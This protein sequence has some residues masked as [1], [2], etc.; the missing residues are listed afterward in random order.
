MAVAAVR[1]DGEPLNDLESFTWGLTE[2]VS[3]MTAEILMPREQAI[4]LYNA[5]IARMGGGSNPFT[6]LSMVADV[7]G[8]VGESEVYNNIVVIGK[9]PSTFEPLNFMY[10]QIADNRWFWDK[11]QYAANFNVRTAVGDLASLRTV[12]ID[13]LG[14]IPDNII[15]EISYR[16]YSLYPPI[17]ERAGTTVLRP[18]TLR[19]MFEELILGDAPQSM[20]NTLDHDV[21]ALTGADVLTALDEILYEEV[22]LNGNYMSAL[23]SLLSFVPHVGI[24][25]DREG[26][27]KF[28]DKS[29]GE[30]QIASLLPAPIDGDGVIEFITNEIQIPRKIHCIFDIQS[31][32][33]FDYEEV[34]T[35]DSITATGEA[36]T[37]SMI[38]PVP[39]PT[40]DIIPVGVGPNAKPGFKALA[41]QPVEWDRV[42]ESLQSAY[43]DIPLTKALFRRYYC[44]HGLIEKFVFKGI[45]AY[46]TADWPEIVSTLKSTYRKNYRINGNWQSKMIGI[47]DKRCSVFD[48]VTGT[49]QDSP[50]FQDY[51]YWLNTKGVFALGEDF[52]NIIQNVTN[53]TDA[54]FLVNTA[55]PM[56]MATVSL[57]DSENG[58]FFVNTSGFD[59]IGH[60]KSIFPS[61]IVNPVTY[62]YA[63]GTKPHH[64]AEGANDSPE[65]VMALTTAHK[66][67]MIISA[68]PAPHP[69][70][71][72]YV[73]EVTPETVSDIV[74]SERLAGAVGP[75]LWVKIPSSV[76]LAR[77]RWKDG[78]DYEA[79]F[80]QLFGVGSAPEVFPE[81]LR[82]QV[83]N[84]FYLEDTAKATGAAIYSEL[85]HRLRGSQVNELE[86]GFEPKGSIT[87]ILNTISS[88]G[89]LSTR[90]ETNTVLDVPPFESFLKSSTRAFIFGHVKKDK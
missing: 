69:G 70:Q 81:I 83:V 80:E 15:D 73:L 26:V 61:T 67:S 17:R 86:P 14:S 32:L 40:L 11:G 34:N 31:E 13:T 55:I 45:L 58:V 51:S 5:G 16:S 88:S 20:K 36:R 50:I 56:G 25:V 28:F 1:L 62:D 41:G 44:F 90:F 22:P 29:Q 87:S 7:K 2:G 42:M 23:S 60:F 82:N 78:A 75:D 3:P 18:F 53:W 54:G 66:M 72:R 52:K 76:D 9:R 24:F 8:R 38:C 37:L 21:S 74:P 89:L 59:P 77:L 19:E 57:T 33:R 63:D 85:I 43:P 65:N 4:N 27:I 64:A 49:L 48:P 35:G 12:E 68:T 71:S 30:E 84:R 39:T 10:L 47:L 46:P 79:A 6:T